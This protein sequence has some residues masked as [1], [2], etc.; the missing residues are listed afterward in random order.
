MRTFAAYPAL[1]HTSGY[2]EYLKKYDIQWCFGSIRKLLD[3]ANWMLNSSEPWKK[4][5]EEKENILKAGICYVYHLSVL[6]SPFI[7]VST[8]KVF[9]AL[10]YKNPKIPKKGDAITPDIDLLN[11]QKPEILFIK[12]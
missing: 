2:I 7:P 6:L 9:R 4:S 12:K 8:E 3:Y 11:I 1:P 10:N 5:G